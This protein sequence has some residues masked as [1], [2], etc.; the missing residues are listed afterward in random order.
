MEIKINKEIRDYSESIFFG[1]SLR[2]FVCALCAVG[3]AVGCYFGLRNIVGVDV[4]TWLCIVA[5]APF[6][7][8]GFIKYNSL[9]AEQFAMAWLR[10]ELMQRKPLPY[11]KGGAA[12]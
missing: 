2:Q 10:S 7:A 4:T 3:A 9:N 5:A 11:Q 1:L 12:P 6:A 8:M